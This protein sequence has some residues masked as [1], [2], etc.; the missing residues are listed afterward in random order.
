MK[1]DELSYAGWV[2]S[3][4][5]KNHALTLEELQ[6]AY[7]KTSFPKEKRPKDKQVIYLQKGILCKRWG[8]KTLHELPVNTQNAV[9]LSGMVRLFL[10]TRV[11]AVHA[12][13]LKFF[14]VDGLTLSDALFANARSM[15]RKKQSPDDNQHSGPRAGKPEKKTRKPRKDRNVGSFDIASLELLIEA[16]KFVVK[17][18]G[19]EVTRKLLDVLESIQA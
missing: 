10:K 14:A 9:N 13:A 1:T 5:L 16:K 19:V 3:M 17:M 18:G 15:L 12:D 7:D 4:I 11:D 8:V 2:R 6:A